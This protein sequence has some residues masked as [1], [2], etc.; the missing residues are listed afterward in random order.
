MNTLV[1]SSA[2]TNF[3]Y[4]LGMLSKFEKSLK[5]VSHIV[6][7]SAGAVTAMFLAAGYS[8]FEIFKESQDR[9]LTREA[10]ARVNLFQLFSSTHLVESQW[11]R[12]LFTELLSKVEIDP[13]IGMKDFMLQTKVRLTI[14]VFDIEKGKPFFFD[15]LSHNTCLIDV[16]M[17]SSAVPF[18]FPPIEIDGKLYCDGA[19]THFFPC[20][21][22]KPEEQKHAVGFLVKCLP[23]EVKSANS[24]DWILKSVLNAI[25]YHTL[26]Y[27]ECSFPVLYVET[28][29]DYMKEGRF[30]F[31]K[32][33]HQSNWT[34]PKTI[35][36]CQEEKVIADLLEK[37]DLPVDQRNADRLR[38]G[39]GGDHDVKKIE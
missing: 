34:F 2:G 13:K 9:Q 30:M 31:E 11:I 23:F 33:V 7:T 19:L 26:C 10:F 5:D 37:G 27:H 21:V 14:P 3:P 6:G 38:I 39:V 25:N 12:D 17:A 8:P 22:L 1:I 32:G 16:V 29:L 35:K 36:K 15:S 24:F 4:L 20:D 18:I 28:N